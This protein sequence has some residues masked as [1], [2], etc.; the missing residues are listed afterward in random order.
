MVRKDSPF[1]SF[2]ELVAYAKA[3][4]GK[5]K[6][7]TVGKFTGDHLFLMQIE[8]L[9]GASFTQVPYPG[10]ARPRPLCSAV[11]WTAISA[12]RPTFFV[13]KAPVVWL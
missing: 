11:K 2:E 5:L 1:Q 12:P 4:R 3:N 9:T 8:K 10:G 7:G 13:W 6:V